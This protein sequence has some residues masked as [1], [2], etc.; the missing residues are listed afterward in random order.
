MSTATSTT[1]HPDVAD[2]TVRDLG[3]VQQ[4]TGLES[5]VDLRLGEVG[6]LVT[7]NNLDVLD[8]LAEMVVEARALLTAEQASA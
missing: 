8:R 3:K 1:V 4:S 2:M 5:L 7:G 6:I